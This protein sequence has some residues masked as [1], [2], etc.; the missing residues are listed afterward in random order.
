MKKYEIFKKD[1]PLSILSNMDG[2]IDRGSWN[3]N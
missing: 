2:F 3:P 1:K